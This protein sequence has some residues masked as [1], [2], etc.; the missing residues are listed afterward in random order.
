MSVAP[1]AFHA[2]RA[3]HAFELGKGDPMT[4][5]I[6]VGFWK[7]NAK[8]CFKE[9]SAPGALARPLAMPGSASLPVRFAGAVL[10]A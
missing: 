3:G 1:A 6:N 9:Q 10:H 2:C 7:S 8:Y 4:W 5:S